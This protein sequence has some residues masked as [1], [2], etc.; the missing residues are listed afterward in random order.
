[1]CLPPD[2]LLPG[3]K[4]PNYQVLFV[5]KPLILAIVASPAWGS[6]SFW[7]NYLSSSLEAMTTKKKSQVRESCLDDRNLVRGRE[8]IKELHLRPL[9]LIV[10]CYKHHKLIMLLWWHF[11]TNKQS[12]TNYIEH[13]LWWRRGIFIECSVK[14]G[15]DDIAH[16]CEVRNG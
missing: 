7:E 10:N 14:A 6:I 15:M 1:M 12:V 2:G 9:I 16:D 13:T 3:A 5:F 11:A 8:L 4:I